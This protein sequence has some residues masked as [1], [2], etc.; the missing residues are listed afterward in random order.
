MHCGRAAR[1]GN[2]VYRRPVWYPS[3]SL[4]RRRDTVFILFFIF[5]FYF[6]FFV[7]LY[8]IFS[9]VRKRSLSISKTT[10]T[11]IESANRCKSDKYVYTVYIFIISTHIINVVS[12]R[13]IFSRF[14]IN[15]QFDDSM[16]IEVILLPGFI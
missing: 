8:F 10:H 3:S 7:F 9:S 15:Y 11:T 6:Y 14:V 13:P 12:R 4:Q 16:Y 1:L 5:F 2:L